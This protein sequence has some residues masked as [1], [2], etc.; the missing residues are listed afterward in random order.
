MNKNNLI[1][2]IN[3]QLEKLDRELNFI[4]SN[5]SEFI[6]KIARRNK[7]FKLKQRITYNRGIYCHD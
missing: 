1:Q 2:V 7:L 5:S 3:I 4:P 6:N